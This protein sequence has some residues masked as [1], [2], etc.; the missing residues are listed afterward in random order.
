MITQIVDGLYFL[1]K[2][3]II[4]RD[5][6]PENILFSSRNPIH[7][8]IS[9][10]GLAKVFHKDMSITESTTY[11]GSFLYASPEQYNG[12]R[13]SFS[14][15]IFS[16]GIILLEIQHI[17]TTGMERII[18]LRD[19]RSNHA[20]MKYIHYKDLI[21]EMTDPEPIKRPTIIQIRNMFL[22]HVIQ[23]PVVICRDIIW[24]IIHS[25]PI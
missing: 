21:L 6:K 5:M 17:F 15:D 13:Y 23:Q 4:H 14:T 3:G 22:D 7:I 12:D 2:N 11:A 16:L 18:V 24:D 8:K 9:D 19:F 25:L 10:F 20:F 1:H